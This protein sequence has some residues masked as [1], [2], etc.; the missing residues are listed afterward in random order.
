MGELVD[1]TAIDLAGTVVG[2]GHPHYVIAEVGA[3]HNGDLELARRH[4]DAAA[5]AGAHAVKFQSWTERSLVS[6]LEYSRNTSYG[7]AHRHFG[8]LK[9]MVAKYALP[10]EA[11][12]ELSRYCREVG[13]HF[14]SSAFAEEEVDLL[15]EVGSVAV[16]IAS[17]DITNVSLIRHAARSGLPVIISSGMASL[18]EIAVAI[19]ILQEEEAEF[20]LMHC[21]AIYPAPPASLNLRNIP[22]FAQAF[23]CPIGFSD[24]SVGTA[25]AT[26]AAALGSCMT[27]KHFTLDRDLPGWDHHMS[28][29][30]EDLRRLV[31]DCEAARQALG[32]PQRRVSADELEKR[33]SFRRSLFARTD[34]PAGHAIR[35]SDLIALRPGTGIGPEHLPYLVGQVLKAPVAAQQQLQRSD[36]SP[37]S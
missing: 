25:A 18:D 5:A 4:V 33:K 6:D 22:T 17:M 12:L 35:A 14:M 8:S 21:V 1:V 2:P 28:A 23:G 29:D 27:E 37:Q 15:A 16:K 7:D 36:F 20:L 9:E 24:H 19:R 13:V 32:S 3:N 11:H 30:P 31:E 26:A 34:L 10:R